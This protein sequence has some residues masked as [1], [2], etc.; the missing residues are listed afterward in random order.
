MENKQINQRIMNY[1]TVMPQVQSRTDLE[2]SLRD[3]RAI[4]GGS[5]SHV[6]SAADWCVSQGMARSIWYPGGLYYR[7]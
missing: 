2:I 7:T 6:W 1:F 4:V 3:L 5:W